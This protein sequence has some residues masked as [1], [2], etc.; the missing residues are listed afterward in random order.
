MSHEGIRIVPEDV[1]RKATGPQQELSREAIDPQHVR[2]NQTEGTGVEIVWKD[3][4][5]S[6][7]TFPWLR[8]ACPCATCVEERETDG[9]EPG[10]PKPEP[11][12]ALPLFKPAIRPNKAH[13]VGRYAI[14]FDWN[15]GHTS[16]IYSWHYLR[17]V[18]NCDA[19]HARINAEAAVPPSKA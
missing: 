13:A 1:A 3:G 8:A 9:R 16:G 2:V 4:H 10:Q 12:T 11:K 14:S 18:C 7:W 6:H 15:D 17:S 5:K 19:C